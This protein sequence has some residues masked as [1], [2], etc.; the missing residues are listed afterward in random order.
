MLSK[1]TFSGFAT[2]YSKKYNRFGSEQSF[3]TPKTFINWFF[4]WSS[5]MRTDFRKSCEGCGD[6]PSVVACDG[7]KVGIGFKETFVTPIETA[8]KTAPKP[9]GKYLRRLNRCYLHAPTTDDPEVNSS[10]K[11]AR[12]FLRSLCDAIIFRRN[13]F[14]NSM[15]TERNIV[16]FKSF[17]EPL[18][19]PAFQNM[20]FEHS[21]DVKK[22]Y[23]S[24]FKLLSY[25]SCADAIISLPIARKVLSCCEK[26]LTDSPEQSEVVELSDLLRHHN[27]QISDLLLK[28]LSLGESTL[29]LLKSLCLFIIKIHDDDID[30]EPSCPI[31]GSYNPPKHGVAYYFTSHGC[32]LR[33]VRSFPIDKES[34]KNFDDVPDVSCMK[35]FPQVSK[36]G[37]SYLFLWFCPLHGH[38]YG[39]HLIPGSE[40]R[41]DAAKSLYS[42]MENPPEV[43]FYDFACSLSEYAKNRESG[44]FQN[45]RF[46]HDYFHGYTHKCTSAF[47]QD[48]LAGFKPVNS[49]ICEQFNS[50]LQCI[51]TSAKL[52]NQ[53]H[54]T[55][56][57]QFMI[58]QW[59]EKKR[60]TFLM[61]E[62]V[63]M[64]SRQ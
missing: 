33:E 13:E 12:L 28:T 45:T 50:F 48:T 43:V 3:M 32:K 35:K 30:P 7:T 22:C 24:F 21:Y 46:Y 2:V 5:R 56:Y 42:Y 25:D 64:M 38:C 29:L 27:S 26:W 60:H 37:T 4:A 15:E 51:K 34:S 6:S 1:Q 36:K 23:A 11:N 18:A 10:Y 61:K 47:R 54:F 62:R 63:A 57:L 44:Y 59:N 40:G 55:F 53:T 58:D 14:V 49:S 41:K 16:A 8:T 17:L 31:E 52:M 19:V 9:K 20:I 39:Y